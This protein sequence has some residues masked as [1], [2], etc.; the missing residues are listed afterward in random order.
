MKPTPATLIAGLLLLGSDFLAI[1]RLLSG[2]GRSFYGWVSLGVFGLI[3]LWFIIR[4]EPL[5]KDGGMVIAAGLSFMGLPV[6]CAA[7][8]V[9]RPGYEPHITWP[10]R[11]ET[12]HTEE[13]QEEPASFKNSLTPRRLQVGNSAGPRI[14]HEKNSLHLK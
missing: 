6:G 4:K 11:E 3:L 1:S 9:C 14:D 8:V 5:W 13:V 7:F 10:L 12:P 2:D